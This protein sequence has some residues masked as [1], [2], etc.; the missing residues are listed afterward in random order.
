MKVIITAGGT[1]EAIDSVRFLGNRSSGKLGALIATEA[2][3]RGHEVLLF[4][5]ARALHPEVPAGGGAFR[6]VT[7]TST[8]DLRRLLTEEAPAFAPQVLIHA[9]AVADFVPELQNGKLSSK[10]EVWLRLLPNE[11]LAPSIRGWCPGVRLVVFKLEA[12]VSQDELFA[13]ARAGLA[14]SGAELVVAN[15]E[16]ALGEDARH[17]AWI[18]DAQRVRSEV[19]GKARIA[20]ALLDLLEE[21]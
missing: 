10:G 12:G 4:R 15:L 5:A 11:K 3:G 14:A 13:R 8:A 16:E 1:E 9:A 17:R 20:A 19:E 2:L 7:F 21:K 18:L 6:C